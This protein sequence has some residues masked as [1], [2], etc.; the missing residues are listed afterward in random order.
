MMS[1]LTHMPS[2]IGWFGFIA[3]STSLTAGPAAAGWRDWL[4]MEPKP[5]P[6]KDSSIFDGIFDGIDP[7]ILL[8]IVVLLIVF[9][10]AISH[11]EDMKRGIAE[12]I[13]R[14]L[15]GLAGGILI[16]CGIATVGAVAGM[17]AV[18][19]YTFATAAIFFVGTMIACAAVYILFLLNA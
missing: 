12:G 17:V 7:L 4:G 11:P 3:A 15:G 8:L 6:L 19:S 18:G 10:W 5:E 2:R 13:G 1:L 14:M 9:G 16:T